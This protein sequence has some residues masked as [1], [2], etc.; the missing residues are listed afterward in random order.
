MI[1]VIS[2]ISSDEAI[3]TA[4]LLAVKEGLLV[5]STVN[6]SLYVSILLVFASLRRFYEVEM[7]VNM[8]TSFSVNVGLISYNLL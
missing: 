4:K 8:D 1:F 7:I 3:E 6:D 5:S 2:Q